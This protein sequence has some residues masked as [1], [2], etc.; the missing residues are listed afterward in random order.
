MALITT[1]ATLLSEVADEV[2]R[3]DLTD[4][5]PRFVQ[6][7]E[8]RLNRLL[9]LK[10]M[11]TTDTLLGVVGSRYIAIPAGYVSPQELEILRGGYRYT[12]TPMTPEQIPK[13]PSTRFP[14]YWAIDN[15]NIIFDQLAPEAF[16][17]YFRYLKSFALSS[18]NT[19]NYLLST[20]PDLYFFA[21][22]CEVGRHTSDANKTAQ[23]EQKFAECAKQVRDREN[24][25]KKIAPLM[26][27][28]GN[29][30]RRAGYNIYKG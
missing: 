15:A 20:D 5:L 24:R 29:L 21:T 18:S 26:T 10:S 25:N 12:P 4:K 3:D 2:H 27:E 16:T 22:L 1:Y 9:F 13:F 11:E 19:T 30:N 7:A 28:L 14:D 6:M 17:V 23:W 8:G